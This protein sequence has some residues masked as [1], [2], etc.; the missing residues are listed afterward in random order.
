MSV[1]T[2][3]SCPVGIRKHV[4]ASARRAVVPLAF[5][6]PG[7]LPQLHLVIPLRATH[8]AESRSIEEVFPLDP[9]ASDVRD[10]KKAPSEVRA[11]SGWVLTR[12]SP[13]LPRDYK[14]REPAEEGTDQQRIRVRAA[15]KQGGILYIA[16]VGLGAAGT[17]AARH[18]PAQSAS[19]FWSWLT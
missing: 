5:P 19:N 8:A 11:A 7:P 4:P 14:A 12:T 17:D 3:F 6:E 13:A 1:F 2:P 16:S 15:S 9:L 18:R 10:G